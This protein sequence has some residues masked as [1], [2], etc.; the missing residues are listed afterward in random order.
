MTKDSGNED[1]PAIVTS[2]TMP[3]LMTD[4]LVTQLLDLIAIQQRALQEHNLSESR[5]QQV[6]NTVDINLHVLDIL[7]NCINGSKR[8]LEEVHPGHPV[9]DVLQQSIENRSNIAYYLAEHY[10]IFLPTELYLGG[11]KETVN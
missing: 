5:V 4:H 10:R 1:A 6:K 3:L 11:Q 9:I 2:I 7:L 8:A